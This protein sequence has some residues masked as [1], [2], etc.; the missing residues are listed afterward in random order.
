MATH[1]EQDMLLGARAAD[2]LGRR[3]M[4]TAGLALCTAGRP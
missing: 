4:F 2:V 1:E 3:R